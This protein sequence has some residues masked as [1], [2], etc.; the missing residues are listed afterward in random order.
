MF[1]PSKQVFIA[2]LN[3][4]GFSASIFDTPAIQ[5]GYP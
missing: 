5:N 4:R 2:L 3:F 1:K